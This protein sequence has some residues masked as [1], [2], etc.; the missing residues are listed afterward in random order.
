MAELQFGNPLDSFNKGQA[1]GRADQFRGLAGMAATAPQDQQAGLL[2]Q[3]IQVDPQQGLA[4][5][6]TLQ[7]EQDQHIKKIANAA[8]Y[9]LSAY[10]TGN[11]AQVE[12][13]YQAVRPYLAEFGQAKGAAPPADHFDPS[14]LPHLYQI[15]G[16]AGGVPANAT[17]GV[18]VTPGGTLVD[19]TTGRPLYH[20]DANPKAPQIIDIPDGNG[21][22]IK[23][24]IGPDGN[25]RPLDYSQMSGRGNAGGGQPDV[26]NIRY[27]GLVEA[28][29]NPMVEEA[30]K[31]LAKGAPADKVAAAMSAKYQGQLG[32]AMPSL[33]LGN[34]GQFRAGTSGDMVAPSPQASAP[35]GGLGYTPPKAAKENAPSGYRFKP[36]GGLEVIPGGPADKTGGAAQAPG[37]IGKTGDD[38][39]SSIGDPQFAAQ[40]KALAEGRLAFPSGTALK[41]P[42]WQQL[43]GAT[44]QYDPNFD[45][46]NYNAR[47]AMRKSA[48]SGPLSK[49]MRALDQVASHIGQ[50][51]D[52]IDQVAG[53][54]Y[55][56]LNSLENR[57]ARATGQPGPIN[58]QSTADAVAHETRALF[59]GAG[60]GTLDE[61]HGYLD[62]LNANNSKEQKQAAIKNISQL[63]RSRIQIIRDQYQQ[64]MGT[65]E[66]PFNVIGAHGVSELDR[67]SGENS[68]PVSA[69]NH[70]QP[71]T[72]AEYD[73]LPSGAT[74]VDPDDGKT[75]R[76]P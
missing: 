4:L 59:A 39:L 46:A 33:V 3:A 11:Q 68:S 9:V 2:D 56:M 40:V 63:V 49:N 34:D 1:Q 30:N 13:A 61:L 31:W 36:D 54:N 22:T 44:A 10:K 27:K 26:T 65:T 45:A 64:G 72:Q 42:H 51:S 37:D 48:T 20:S 58:W 66:D 19:K 14:M 62:T 60:G 23:A 67:L 28:P 47:V 57:Y 5:K 24:S 12:G 16:Q 25:P 52:Q 71:K 53:G 32:G 7:S 69:G 70:A 15:I 8:N 29:S 50:L 43:L 6:Q 75:Y 17:E 18:V 76:K 73:A 55:P 38:Y 35:V 41:D 74:F 21:G